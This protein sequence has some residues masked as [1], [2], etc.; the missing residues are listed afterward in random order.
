MKK[1]L[2][3]VP[4]LHQGGLER[5]CA[6]TAGLLQPYY[7]VQIALFDSRSVAYDIKGIP[8]VD[9]RLP[10]RPDKLGKIINVFKRGIKLRRLKKKE[11]IDIA[12][13]FGP[14]ANLANIF[15]GDSAE[16]WLGVRSYMDMGNPRQMR[17]FC[18]HSDR[19]VCCSETI[20]KEIEEKYHCPHACTLHNP[21]DTVQIGVLAAKEQVKLP[22][23]EGRI[24]VSMGREDIVKGYWHL[25]KIFSEV[26]KKLPDTKLMIIGKGEFEDYRKLATDL[27]IDDA[28]YFTGFKKNP[29]PYLKKSTLYVLTS[30]YEGFPNALVEAMA[31]GIPAV[32]TDC[33]TG[34]GEILENKYGILVPNMDAA[35]DLNAAVITEEEKAVAARIIS[36]LENPED[37]E[38]YR[39]LSKE[40]AA[41]YSAEDYVEQIRSW[42]N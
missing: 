16:R 25:L 17:F 10:S 39:K 40:R 15:S 7:D 29:Y 20:H 3:I 28:V 32:A 37:M 8:V 4:S 38:R 42:A 13:S 35:C 41:M 2:L 24:I 30:Y 21:I 12:Y 22:W 18:R 9:L 14:T 19:M 1:L 11:K 6:V 33:M 36:L 5:V 23:D 34:P 27:K 26:H 31:L